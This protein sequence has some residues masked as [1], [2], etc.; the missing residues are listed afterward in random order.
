M[1]AECQGANIFIQTS[2]GNITEFIGFCVAWWDLHI[3]VPLLSS[4]ER[5]S[6]LEQFSNTGAQIIIFNFDKSIDAIM[7]ICQHIVE[8]KFHMQRTAAFL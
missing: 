7:S 8:K 3:M 1:C 4:H 6:L 2:S 5:S